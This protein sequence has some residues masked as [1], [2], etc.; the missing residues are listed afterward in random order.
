[1]SDLSLVKTRIQAGIWEGVLSGGL[2]TGQAPEIEVSH[3]GVP[4]QGVAVTSDGEN[5]GSW[6]VKIAIPPDL[7]S[8]GVQTFLIVDPDAGEVLNSFTI[9][10]G[11]PLEDDIRGELDLLRAELDMLKRAF[12]RHCVETM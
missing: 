9:V 2:G 7:L 10:T 5:P 12:R 8:D 11:E 6:N 1:M 4:V 3:Q